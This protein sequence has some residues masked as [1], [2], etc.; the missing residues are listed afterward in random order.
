MKCKSE[1]GRNHRIIHKLNCEYCG[2]EYES[3][4]VKDRKYCCMIA[5][6]VTGF[7]EKK[8]QMKL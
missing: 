5:T 4:G 6:Y 2:K 8:M 1:W 7:G 3:L